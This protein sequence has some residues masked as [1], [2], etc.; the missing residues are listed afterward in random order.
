MELFLHRQRCN[1]HLVERTS[2]AFS[3]W[4]CALKS[5]QQ[6]L[7]TFEY[8]FTKAIDRFIW[9]HADF[10]VWWS[11]VG[12]LAFRLFLPRFFFIL[13]KNQLSDSIKQCPAIKYTFEVKFSSNAYCIK[14]CRKNSNHWFPENQ[15]SVFTGRMQKPFQ[16]NKN[17]SNYKN[18]TSLVSKPQF[19]PL[20]SNHPR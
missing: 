19:E 12:F 20:V 6:N 5:I 2:V 15:K 3:L 18:F 11:F 13:L 16:H 1:S 17:I 10:V 7:A 8:L 4:S 14:T 9:G